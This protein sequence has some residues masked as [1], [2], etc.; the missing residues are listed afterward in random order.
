MCTFGFLLCWGHKVL[1]QK[2]LKQLLVVRNLQGP[3]QDLLVTLSSAPRLILFTM[4]ITFF[5]PPLFCVF[6]CF[7]LFALLFLSALVSV[8]PALCPKCLFSFLINALS[9]Y[10]ISYSPLKLLSVCHFFSSLHAS[11]F[12]S[13][14]VCGYCSTHFIHLLNI[15]VTVTVTSSN[16][17]WL[18]LYSCTHIT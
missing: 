8:F 13:S 2:W 11:F 17:T 14:D 12:H 18:S 6:V 15:T 3:K 7:L 10:S 16:F 9:F 4:G 5:S 1:L